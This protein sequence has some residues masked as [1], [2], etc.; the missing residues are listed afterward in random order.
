MFRPAGHELH[1]LR[2]QGS[3]IRALIGKERGALVAFDDRAGTPDI[4]Q[5]AR[6]PLTHDVVAELIT[7]RPLCPSVTTRTTPFPTC[8][9]AAATPWTTA[10][11]A[12][13]RSV[14]TAPHNARTTIA[15]RACFLMPLSFPVTR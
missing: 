6:H 8:L 15:S 7:H 12:R 9:P 3:T 13:P 11:P 10:C 2:V 14:T 4:L 5:V 1:V